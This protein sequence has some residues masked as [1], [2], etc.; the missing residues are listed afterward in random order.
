M[1][2]AGGAAGVLLGG[3]ITDLLSWRWILF[4][5][6]PIGLLAA[7]FAQRLIAEGRDPTAARDF[8]LRG[9]LSATL[10][11][12][13]LVL[14]HRPHRSRPAGARPATLALIGAG[15]ALLVVFVVIEGRFAHAPLMPLRIF[16]SRT[17]TRRTSSC[18]WS[19]RSTL[20]D[21]VLPVALSPAG[22]RLLADQAPGWRSCR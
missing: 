15:I 6:V 11:L 20:R 16:A 19:A 12:S 5:N 8:D 1:G 14:G 2:G 7:F 18:C 22:A 21:V 3:I 13:L 9:A 10:G 17:L 4:I